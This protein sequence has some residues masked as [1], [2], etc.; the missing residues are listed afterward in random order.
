MKNKFRRNMIVI[1]MTLTVAL[2]IMLKSKAVSATELPTVETPTEEVTSDFVEADATVPSDVTDE[3]Y[4]EVP[5]A[6]EADAAKLASIIAPE[7]LADLP[8]EASPEVFA[9][10][11]PAP[12]ILEELSEVPAG[13]VAQLE[14]DAPNESL[15][16]ALEEVDESKP[17]VIIRENLATAPLGIRV[18]R[19]G[20]KASYQT[21]ES[22]ALAAG[23]TGGTA[24]YRYQFFILR[25]NGSQVILRNFSATNHFSWKPIT[26][27]EYR[28]GVRIMDDAG[29]TVVFLRNVTVHAA[30]LRVAVFRAG[31][32]PA[33]VK[34]SPIMLAARAEGGYPAYRY[35]F[36][37]QRS[38]GQRV[39][40]RDY[41]SNNTFR[42]IPVT[43][44]RYV[45]TAFAKDAR[46]TVKGYSR[47]VTI[48]KTPPLEVAVFRAGNKTTYRSADLINLAARG[49]GGSSPYR[50]QY[51]LIRSNGVR[52]NLTAIRSS[53]IAS[54][55]PS[56]PGTYT[57]GVVIRDKTGA[58]V[59]AERKISVLHSVMSD[60]HQSLNQNW[61][62]ISNGGAS[63]LGTYA[64]LLQG[65][66]PYL[67][68]FHEENRSLWGKGKDGSDYLEVKN[69]SAEHLTNTINS[70]LF[71]VWTP[72]IGHYEDATDFDSG[73]TG[74][75]R[76]KVSRVS[77]LL[78]DAYGVSEATALKAAKLREKLGTGYVYGGVR[79]EAQYNWLPIVNAAKNKDGVVRIRGYAWWYDIR[80]ASPNAPETLYPVEYFYV[81]QAGSSW[82]G[83]QL[84]TIR[85]SRLDAQGNWVQGLDYGHLPSIYTGYDKYADHWRSGR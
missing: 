49:T 12:E 23:A 78:T 17:P 38:N 20:Y 63:T 60:W 72:I 47:T 79:T 70:M 6:E 30:P 40:L 67:R 34:N 77:K 16:T 42:W 57:L 68:K 48:T 28:V 80:D 83:Y 13:E 45:V 84:K 19:T 18:F 14:T 9:A 21:Y 32:K 15:S 58:F 36:V 35:R 44:D 37:V 22:I 51:Y 25:S 3:P 33:V 27:D 62:T 85:I 81:P 46:G 26:P 24:P 8:E 71:D 7:V 59:R 55:R 56:T 11:T 64:E 50:Y 5:Q 61:T 66:G 69:L 4:E 1:F 31:S 73:D 53:N 75:L 39:L 2:L 10:V 43:P 41:S 82:D 54:W 76:V 65:H 74:T 52:S 29:N